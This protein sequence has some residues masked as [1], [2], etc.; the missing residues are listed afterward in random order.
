MAIAPS[1]ITA[2]GDSMVALPVFTV[3]PEFTPLPLAITFIAAAP[4]PLTGILPLYD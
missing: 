3:A 4:P 1:S 2:L